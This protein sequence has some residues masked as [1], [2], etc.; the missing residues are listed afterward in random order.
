MVDLTACSIVWASAARR[1]EEY[2]ST[3]REVIGGFGRNGSWRQSLLWSRVPLL[4]MN[5]VL[6]LFSF[7]FGL[8]LFSAVASV[9]QVVSRLLFC[10]HSFSS[11]SVSVSLSLVLSGIS[12]ISLLSGGALSALETPAGG[13]SHYV[14]SFV[15]SHHQPCSSSFVSVLPVSLSLVLSGISAISLLSGGAL[16]ALETPAGGSS[17][18]VASFVLSHHQPC[19]LSFV[20]VL[21]VSLSLVLSGISAISLLSGGALSALETPAGCSSH[22]VASFVLSHHQ[23]CSLS[24]VSVLPV[25]RSLVLSGISAISFL[26]GGALS[27]FVTPAGD[28]S[29]YVASFVLFH[30]QPCSF[31]SVSVLSVSVFLV[32]SRNSAISLLSGGALL[33]LVTPAGS[34]SHYV[35]SFVLSHHQPCSSSSVSVLPVSLSLVLSGISAISLL[36]GGASSALVTP[37]GDSSR[38]VASFVLFHPQPCS[39][40]SVSVLSVSVFLVLSRNSAISFLSGGALSALVTPVGGIHHVATRTPDHFCSPPCSQLLLLITH[41]SSFVS[42]IS[43]TIGSY[44]PAFWATLSVCNVSR[45]AIQYCSTK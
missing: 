3:F 30:P 16:S 37:A 13:S 44:N 18:Y 17:H 7:C 12:A 25:S 10:R 9:S 36:S 21:P 8:M 15:L 22:Y 41:L 39:F 40:S 19:S 24:F 28:S 35:A 20:S 5:A 33:A 23:P 1:G 38:Y 11:V 29:H 14:A 45:F 34:S 43:E 4:G 42:E 26:S 6:L 32:L 2:K 27:A 31:S